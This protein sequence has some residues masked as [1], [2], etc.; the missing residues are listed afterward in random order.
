MWLVGVKLEHDC[1]VV[2]TPL[3]Q[4]T[5][6][7]PDL[8]IVVCGILRNGKLIVPSG[9]NHLLVGDNIYIAS[10][11]RSPVRTRIASST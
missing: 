8:N 9:N 2:D 3:R 10:G 11:P 6:L 1:P 5:E 4:L 7:F